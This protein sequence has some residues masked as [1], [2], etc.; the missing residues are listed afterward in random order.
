MTS[1]HCSFCF[2]WYPEVAV[3]K[4]R[5]QPK[6]TSLQHHSDSQP[7]VSNQAQKTEMSIRLS[8]LT[9]IR[10][11]Q[12]PSLSPYLLQRPPSGHTL[13]SPAQGLNYPT[14]QILQ[15][16]QYLVILPVPVLYLL[17][18]LPAV[19]VPGYS[20]GL[21]ASWFAHSPFNS[22]PLSISVFK[23][24]LLARSSLDSPRAD[25][26]S[27]CAC[28]HMY[29]K[30]YLY[31]RSNHFFLPFYFTIL[32]SLSAFY[33]LA[34]L[35]AQTGPLGQR[36]FLCSPSSSLLTRPT[37][38]RVH[39]GVSHMSLSLALSVFFLLPT[40]NLLVYLGAVISSFAFLLSIQIAEQS[41]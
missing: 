15:P 4:W 35:L 38:G 17:S 16:L 7:Q 1:H 6:A 28:P 12:H 18:W 22:S 13:N 33:L 5:Y 10:F 21:R 29:N 24:S 8:K 26:S 14:S 32:L 36:L 9:L 39:S 37:F 34:S 19:L 2:D 40:V 25:T 27:S 23:L 3:L 31:F 41:M 11:S 30:H 20:L